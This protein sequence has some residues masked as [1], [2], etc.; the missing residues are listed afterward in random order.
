[1]PMS[2]PSFE[3]WEKPL[4]RSVCVHSL[5]SWK[6]LLHCPP[7]TLQV[8][9][10]G[11]ASNPGYSSSSGVQIIMKRFSAVTVDETAST[12]VIGMGLVWDDV[13][14]ALEPYSVNVVGGRVTGVGVAGFALG[15]GY[16]WKTSQYGLTVDNIVEFDLVLPNGTFVQVT[17]DNYPDLMWG[18][19]GGYNNFG[20][21]TQITMKTYLQ[22][23]VWVSVPWK[24]AKHLL[25]FG[26]R[27]VLLPILAMKS[28]RWSMQR[29]TLLRRILTLKRL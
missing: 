26:S 21:V 15:G 18:L 3:Y 14:E 25:I 27:E 7:P 29:T 17:E 22:T 13:Y 10:G 9:G 11:H 20:I 4:L 5:R 2:E 6:C 1:M 23:E 16:S 8:K 19:K 12:A 28:T 24:E